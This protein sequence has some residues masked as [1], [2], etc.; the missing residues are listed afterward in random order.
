MGV[1]DNIFGGDKGPAVP[2]EAWRSHSRTAG[3]ARIPARWR[4]GPRNDSPRQLEQGIFYCNQGKASRLTVN[5]ERL[6]V[7]AKRNPRRE[8]ADPGR[9][10]LDGREDRRSQRFRPA[11][12]VRPGEGFPLVTTKKVPFGA[13]VHELIWFLRGST[14]IAYL[15]E[16]GSRSGTSGPTRGGAWPGLRQAVAIVAGTRRPG[17]RPDREPGRGDQGRHGRSDRL[18]RT[19]PDRLGLEPRRH[20]RDGAAALP[21]AL[22]VQRDR[23]Q[24]LV[25]ALPALGRP[26]PGRAVQHRQLRPAHPPRGARHGPGPPAS[27]ST[28]SAMRTSTRT[29]S[30]RSTHSLARA[31]AAPPDRDRSGGERPGADRARADQADRLSLPPRARRRGRRLGEPA[32]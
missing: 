25:P 21:Y 12:P 6:L 1:L 10:S 3:F 28:P 19:A 4:R 30:T 24:A 27:S 29:I 20:R 15:K 22:P 14:N 23:G 2:G 8:E 11:D 16:H 7:G 18:G 13:I 17:D 5:L 26:V 32:P 9:A 31:P